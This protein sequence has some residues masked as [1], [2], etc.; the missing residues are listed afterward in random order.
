MAGPEDPDPPPTSSVAHYTTRDLLLYA[1]GIGC[2]SDGSGGGG[3]EDGELRYVHEG[4]AFFAPFPTFPLALGFTSLPAG[5]GGCAPSDPPRPSFGIRPFPPPT[6]VHDSLLPRRLLTDPDLDVGS[7]P[8]VHIS[9]SLRLHRPVPLPALGRAR[10]RYDPLDAPGYDPPVA[11][12]LSTRTVSVRPTSIGAFVETETEYRGVAEGGGVAG[13]ALLLFTARSTVLVAGVPKDAALPFRSGDRQPGPR[14][15]RRGRDGNTPPD[16][17]GSYRIA[18]NQALLYRLSGD[19]NAIHV[20]AALAERALG[21]PASGTGRRPVLHGLCTLGIAVRAVLAH[22]RGGGG[23]LEGLQVTYV[24]ADFVRPVF[25]GDD[26]EV[27]V[28]EGGG[29]GGRRQLR[30]QASEKSSGKTVVERG[31]V[32]LSPAGGGLDAEGD[33]VGARSRL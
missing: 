24:S 33:P 23:G 3:G 4:H 13:R 22:Q 19:Y 28:W 10:R 5:G 15:P 27:A 7:F 21:R 25:V 16:H 30:F 1:V 31:S 32:E 17:V 14:P 11:L 9:Q 12:D 2:C 18:P 6:M 20:D 8:S 29:S 26:I